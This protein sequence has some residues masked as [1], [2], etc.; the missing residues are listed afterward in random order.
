MKHTSYLYRIVLIGI[1]LLCSDF[2]LAQT[3]IHPKI[4]G[5]GDLWVN[6]Y[7]GVLFFGR[8]DITSP[9]TQM[10]LELRFY[11]NSSYADKNIGFGNGFTLEAMMT[12]EIDAI[13]GVTIQSGDGRQD[14]YVKYDREYQAPAGIYATLTQPEIDKYLLVTKTGERY[15]F[16]NTDY[17]VLTAKQ[18][19]FGNRT[20]YTYTDSLLTGI[21]DAVG[22]TLTLTWENGLLTQAAG[23]T[24][25]GVISYTYDA[26]GHL[27]SVKNPDGGTITYRYD[28]RNRINRIVDAAGCTTDISYNISGMTSRLKT[29]DSDL[30]IRYE[31]DRTLFIT[32]TQ[33]ANQYSYFKWDNKGRV[34]EQVGL[35]CGIQSKIRY[36]ENDNVIARTDANGNTSHYTYDDKGNMLSATDAL[37]HTERYTYT[38]DFN[39]VASYQDKNGNTYRFTYDDKGCLTQINAP[40]G[41]TSRFEY[42]AHGW[43]TRATDANGNVTSTQYN[44][45][46]TI[47]AITDPAGYTTQ[48]AYDQYG[49]LT[50]IRDAQQHSTLYQ[51][52]AMGRVIQQTNA[53]GGIQTF[54][55]D[56]KGRIVRLTDEAGHITAFTY[57]SLDNITSI[58]NAIGQVTRLNYDGN[59][60]VISVTDPLGRQS[61]YRWDDRHHLLSE[62]N[63]AGETN[64]YD[65]DGHGN[66]ITALM[67]NGNNFTYDYDAASR[68][69]AINDKMGLVASYT[70][71]ANGNRLTETDGEGRTMT[72]AYD[73]LNR[74]L[75]ATTPAK[76]VTSY[77][78]DNNSNITAIQDALSN[79]HILT[80]SSRDELLSEED[81]LHAQTHY[82][83]DGNGNLTRITDARGNTTAYS[84]DALDRN[85]VI[86]FANAR[87]FQ[88]TYD[89][90]GNITRVI[91]RAGNAINLSYD[92]VGRLLSRSY[93]DGK[94]DRYTYDAVGQLVAATNAAATISFTYDLAGRVLSETL[95][96]KTTSYAYLTAENIRRLTYPSGTL[97]E[98][99]LNARNQITSII[100]NGSEVMQTEYNAASQYTRRVLGNGVNTQYTYDTNGRLS[101]INDNKQL[102]GWQMTYDAVGNM[103][104]RINTHD[105]SRT[106]T[107]TYDAIGQLT[108]MQRG[109]YSVAWQYDLLN[110]RTRV[111]D[112]GQSVSYAADNMNAYTSI[113][114]QTAVSPQYDNNGNLLNDGIHTYQYDLAN[115]LIKTDADYTY[116]YD[117]LGRRIAKQTPT[118]QLTYFY[119]GDQIVEEYDS[120]QLAR[121][122]VYGNDI[123]EIL[124]MQSGENTY[125][126][127]TN[128]L[129]S[130]MAISDQTG[131]RVE[132]M[133]YDAYGTPTFYDNDGTIMA[134]S[135]IGN[136]ILFTGREYDYESGNYYFR[137]RHLHPFFGRFMQHDPLLYIDGMNDYAYVLN[138]PISYSDNEGKAIPVAALAI[139]AGVG[140]LWGAGSELWG[141]GRDKGWDCID[142]GDV[143]KEALKGAGIGLAATAAGLGLG[144]AGGAALQGM[145]K[146]MPAASKWLQGMGKAMSKAFSGGAK[147][148]KPVVKPNP[149][150]DKL[151]DTTLKGKMNYNSSGKAPEIEINPN[152]NNI[153]KPKDMSSG[154]STPK[155]P[156]AKPN[157]NV[158]G[159]K[160]H[161][162]FLNETKNT[163]TGQKLYLL[164]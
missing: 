64:S 73:A 147:G 16:F 125:Y 101:G 21:R 159:E 12:Y 104:S 65:Y 37:G 97:I 40:L 99:R 57:N 19:R 86:T 70:Y 134:Q 92:A 27:Q 115:R 3:L 6:S 38:S 120:N 77:T 36:D 72:Y 58:T 79:R 123:D 50:S 152:G 42:D 136:T 157:N 117:A 29:A 7:N 39:Q 41:V 18:D 122:Y 49:N 68:L 61:F 8:T 95:N 71:D 119:V 93:A 24:L 102:S 116:A 96:G 141:Q 89:A 5:P 28:N 105:A 118:Q 67:A 69:T 43:Q 44:E 52:D 163:V 140:A 121:Q 46:G 17:P 148:G 100:K 133:D 26:N 84:Y 15:E 154:T 144:A 74:I 63:P 150:K 124:Q 149:P 106:E 142:W 94:T 82:E 127:H 158:M 32:Y 109:A 9:N 2:L 31:K 14:L 34:I 25:N 33:P 91:D 135:K 54:S 151:L 47:A 155:T 20:E 87:S 107:Y 53:L 66:L 114:G 88:Y 138:N 90:V 60:N 51:V 59:G 164:F 128:H 76:E 98:E 137:A 13:G 75:T 113:G 103:L 10:P 35:C 56:K 83:Y 130:V 162:W 112:N 129:G 160:E 81:A 80:Y 55:Y 108:Q 11:Y 45:N 4:S 23:S 143:G 139:G 131:N 126:Y 161:Q 85:T 145:G 146:A 132:Y 48:Y 156:T 1:V 110:N 30:S 153:F 62:T 111:N 78:Y 22:H